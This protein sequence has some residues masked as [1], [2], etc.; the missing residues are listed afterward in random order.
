ME[1]SSL[2]WETLLFPSSQ[3]N[4]LT[5]SEEQFQRIAPLLLKEPIFQVEIT[6]MD[7]RG[8]TQYTLKR[9]LK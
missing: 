3:I 6:L 5:S 2:L 8:H 7:E 1:E 4:Q 9:F